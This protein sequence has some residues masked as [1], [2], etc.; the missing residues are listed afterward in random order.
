M[1][2]YSRRPPGNYPDAHAIIDTCF[3]LLFLKQ[4]NLARDLTGK[5]QLLA[6]G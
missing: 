4:A 1:G 3:A 2:R 6:G 5:L